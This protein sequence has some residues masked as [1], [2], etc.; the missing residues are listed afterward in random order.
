MK[1]LN[2]VVNASAGTRLTQSITS[3][4]AVG[5]AVG[6]G[7]A[8]VGVGVGLALVVG[9]GAASGESTQPAS[10]R[11]EAVAAAMVRGSEEPGRIHPFCVIAAARSPG[12]TPQ[13][14]RVRAGR[15]GHRESR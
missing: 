9:V 3:G 4:S 11:I 12:A 14:P 8:A 2:R 1:V 15:L 13:G 5:V 6:V 10:R 7:L